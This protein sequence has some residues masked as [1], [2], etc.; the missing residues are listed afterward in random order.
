MTTILA[1]KDKE[2]FYVAADSQ[3]TSDISIHCGNCNKIVKVHNFVGLMCGDVCTLP[4][5][6][7]I[8]DDLAKDGKMSVLELQRYILDNK[9]RLKPVSE[10]DKYNASFFVLQLSKGGNVVKAFEIDWETF[11]VEEWQ[12]EELDRLMAFGSGSHFATGA[13]KTF[14]KTIPGQTIPQR[15]ISS[16]TIAADLDLYTNKNIKVKKFKLARN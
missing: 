5:F 9:E 2:Y 10:E 13:Y 15:L 6:K 8:L 7:M 11:S 1:V 16:I 12:I 14:E 3:A 4:L